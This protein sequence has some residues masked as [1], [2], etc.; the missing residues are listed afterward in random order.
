LGGG[1]NQIAEVGAF[2][3]KAGDM[4]ATFPEQK[5]MSMDSK[6][7]ANRMMIGLTLLMTLS[8]LTWA[9]FGW[10][11]QPAPD[12]TLRDVQGKEYS[13]SQFKNKVVVL[14]FFTIWCMPCREEMPEL[15]KIYQEYKDKGV[16]LL[17]VCL[18]PDP[19]QFRAL[20][21]MLNLDYPML[22]GTDQMPKLYADLAVVPTTF[23]IDRKG[24]IIQRVIGAKKKEEFLRMIKPLL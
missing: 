20:V 16:Q 19:N 14:N 10:A 18:K 21:K 2:W 22:A 6:A 23:I 17:G 1:L 15:N 9:A 13:L 3:Y 4:G 8:L 24:N 7:P 5:E 12:F 11:A